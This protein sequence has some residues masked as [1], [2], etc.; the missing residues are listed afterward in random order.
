MNYPAWPVLSF[1]AGVIEDVGK[2]RGWEAKAGTEGGRVAERPPR[3]A[4]RVRRG[5]FGS[6]QRFCAR[7]TFPHTSLRPCFLEL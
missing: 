6:S 7:V 1:L 3:V 5:V 2:R 4:R